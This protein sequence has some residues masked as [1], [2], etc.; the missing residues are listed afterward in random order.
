MDANMLKNLWQE[1]DHHPFIETKCLEDVA[2]LKNYIEIDWVYDFLVGL[3]A[4][5]DQ[6]KVQILNKK[7]STLNETI[8]IIR[9][10]ESKK[11]VMLEPQNLEG[12]AMVAN[13]ET[14]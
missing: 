8:S 7:L 3:N 11:S 10:E 4:E 9:V 5:F 2:I 13:K 12:L 14:D 1:L 6:V